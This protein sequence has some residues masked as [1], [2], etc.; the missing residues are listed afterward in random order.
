MKNWD[1]MKVNTVTAD[2]VE[3]LQFRHWPNP[4][5]NVS[6]LFKLHPKRQNTVVR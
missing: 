2:Q 6:P 4:P 1:G 3:W 5:Q